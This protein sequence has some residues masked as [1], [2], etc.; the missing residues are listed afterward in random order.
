MKACVLEAVG[1]LVYKET[2]MPQPKENEILLKIKACGICSSDIDRVFKTGTYHFPTIPG[3]EFSGEIVELG[4]AAEQ[5]LLGKRAV[6]F[7]LL[8]CKTCAS[9]QER[10]FARCENYNYF[11]SRCDGAFAE[12]LAVPIWNIIT[13]SQKLDYKTAA[14]CEPASVARH[15]VLA[16]GNLSEKTIAIVGTGTIAFLTAMWARKE[17]AGKIIMIGRSSSKKQFAE[18]IGIDNFVYLYQNIDEQVAQITNNRGADIIFECVGSEQAVEQ[19][20]CLTRKGGVLILTGN[21]QS[22]I[23]LSRENYWK[24]LRHELT[25]RGIWNSSYNEEINDWKETIKMMEHNSGQF[26]KLITH[27]FRLEQH[28]DAFE[29]IMD[30]N[31]FSLKV[32]FVN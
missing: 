25:V 32:M 14:L 3:H 7:P 20:I 13:F 28:K 11:G 5:S 21:P 31:I 29:T 16:A 9:C 19:S 4:Q 10:Q 2:Q 23:S 30:Q 15:G 24:I 26:Q 27:T 12:Y 1:S 18:T 22:D 17:G 8:P 6:V